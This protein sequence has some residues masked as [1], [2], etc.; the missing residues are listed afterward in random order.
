MIETQIKQLK[1]YTVYAGN[2]YE[3]F[4]GNIT[5]ISNPNSAW[6]LWDNAFEFQKGGSYS[7]TPL[8]AWKEALHLLKYEKAKLKRCLTKNEFLEKNLDLFHNPFIQKNIEYK[9][10]I[11]RLKE[12]IEFVKQRIKEVK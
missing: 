5:D 9:N 1:V 11:E 7:Y 3:G 4:I 10:K 2:L 8:D 12:N 6:I